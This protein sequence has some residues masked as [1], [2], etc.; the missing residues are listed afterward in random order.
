[1]VETGFASREPGVIEVCLVGLAWRREG[2]LDFGPA[3]VMLV[4]QWFGADRDW[5]EEEARDGLIRSCTCP[6]S[7]FLSGRF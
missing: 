3:T 2:G 1:M 4:S 5:S 7:T 6:S